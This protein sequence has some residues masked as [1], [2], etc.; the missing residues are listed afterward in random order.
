MLEANLP[1]IAGANHTLSTIAWREEKTNTNSNN[2]INGNNNND[3]NNNNNINGN[4]TNDYHDSYSSRGGI[5]FPL[6][7][8]RDLLSLLCFSP[9]SPPDIQHKIFGD[10]LTLFDI[11][12][13]DTA[14]H[15]RHLREAMLSIWRRR[16]EGDD[17]EEGAVQVQVPVLVLHVDGGGGGT[18]SSDRLR[19]ISLRGISIGQLKLGGN[20]EDKDFDDLDINLNY[21]KHLHILV[22]CRLCA[23]TSSLLA[24]PL[25]AVLLSYPD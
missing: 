5:A 14:L 6:P 19:W 1:D 2:N 24:P 11:G 15:G 7:P 8:Y 22:G 16:R 4:N 25:S 21:V 18:M 23:M 3:S 10:Y 17:D 12:R 20:I 9:R 13:L